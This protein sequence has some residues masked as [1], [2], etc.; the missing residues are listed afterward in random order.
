MPEH[1]PTDAP[2]AAAR[3][4]FREHL[5]PIV[6]PAPDQADGGGPDR[7]RALVATEPMPMHA[8]S[9][10][11]SGRAA[12][13][14]RTRR[15]MAVAAV[16]A[17]LL[18]G[19][20]AARSRAIDL[21]DEADVAT[22]APGPTGWYVPVGL[23]V[24]WTLLGAEHRDGGPT[25][26]RRGS[27]W[28]DPQAG[29]AMGL[30]FDACGTR[31]SDDRLPRPD[32]VNPELAAG[33]PTVEEVDLGTTTATGPAFDGELRTTPPSA[34]APEQRMLTWEGDG[35]AWT[36]RTIGLSEEEL[37]D[38]ART[39]A[40]DPAGAG[41]EAAG[42]GAGL[43]LVDRWEAPERA[44]APE[45]QLSLRSPDGGGVGIHLHLPGDGVRPAGD[46]VV[47]PEGLPG[48]SAR[49]LRFDDPGW[50][51]RFGAAWVGADLTVYRWAEDPAGWIDDEQLRT[52]IAALR[53]ASANT[54]RSYL[55]TAS[56]DVSASLLEAQDLTALLDIDPTEPTPPTS[57]ESTTSTTDVDAGAPAADADL[58]AEAELVASDGPLGRFSDLTGLVVRLA[59]A[60][61]VVGTQP[62]GGDS[63]ILRNPTDAPIVVNECSSLLTTW[64]LVPHGADGPL[65]RRLVIDCFDTPI[66]TVPPGGTVVVPLV[67][68]ADRGFVARS[69]DES[70]HGGLLGTLPAGAYDAVVDLPTARGILRARVPVQIA[71]PACPMTD[72]E[73]EAYRG[74]PADEAREA[75]A[76]DGRELVVVVEDGEELGTGWDL[77][78]ARLRAVIAGGVITDYTFG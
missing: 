74:L 63:L 23:P 10:D 14:R 9:S 70:L 45:V 36:L 20:V 56:G 67:W 6:E 31:F 62:G 77:D 52:L 24:G 53:P 25:C 48:R 40:A 39:A 50:A 7:H 2:D 47:V 72:A 55:E 43:E 4:W 13:T 71:T 8:R 32:E 46:T 73:A 18:G 33:F 26:E 68:G 16:V 35:G 51:G 66:T 38:A 17:L 28:T 57:E 34:F 30:A 12:A 65:P 1:D 44:G 69:V 59:L 42:L 22:V 27:Q 78:C 19:A 21:R 61:A 41:A 76:Q 49:V 75:A 11:A 29:R 5:D 60:D 3:A 64:G 15:A 54:W 58:V 37:L